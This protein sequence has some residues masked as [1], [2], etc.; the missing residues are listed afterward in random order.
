MCF[1][2]YGSTLRGL[3]RGTRCRLYLGIELG[4]AVPQRGTGVDVSC[5]VE[6]KHDRRNVCRKQGLACVIIGREGIKR[7]VGYR[8]QTSRAFL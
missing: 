2:G 1:F 7:T 4:L 3:L 8:Q 6:T 5:H